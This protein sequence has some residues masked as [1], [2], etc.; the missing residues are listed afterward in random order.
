MYEENYNIEIEHKDV[1]FVLVRFTNKSDGEIKR[2]RFDLDKRIFID[3]TPIP[4]NGSLRDSIVS[5]YKDSIHSNEGLWVVSVCKLHEGWQT[6]KIFRDSQKV[7]MDKFILEEQL[8]HNT[9]SAT[10]IHGMAVEPLRQFFASEV[11]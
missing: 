4:P 11:K 7:E 6:P 9:V 10:R 2:A 1:P 5:M 3:P 8:Q